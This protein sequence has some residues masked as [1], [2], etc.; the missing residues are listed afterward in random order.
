MVHVTTNYCSSNRGI[1][2]FAQMII[3]GVILILM[4]IVGF[5]KVFEEGGQ[6]A[7]CLVL[8]AVVL[9]ILIIFF[10]LNAFGFGAWRLERAF[11]VFCIFLFVVAFALLLWYVIVKWHTSSHTFYF[12]AC[13]VLTALL[14]FFFLWDVKILQ[15]EA[16]NW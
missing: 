6:L 5:E 10:V 14:C 12:V 7:F 9:I 11:A 3:C 1:V 2:K 4:V 16:S 15:G 13:A 8:T